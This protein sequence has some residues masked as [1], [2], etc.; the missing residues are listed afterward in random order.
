[1]ET[2]IGI[3]LVNLYVTYTSAPVMITKLASGEF[4]VNGEAAFYTSKAARDDNQTPVMRLPVNMVITAQ[5]LSQG[6]GLLYAHLKGIY[7]DAV[8]E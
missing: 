4:L 7:T 2:D 1:M 3:P 5:Q 6:F 8:D